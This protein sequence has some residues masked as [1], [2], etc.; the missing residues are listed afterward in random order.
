[1]KSPSIIRIIFVYPARSNDQRNSGFG[2]SG[3][4]SGG[5]DLVGLFN[6]VIICLHHK[7]F[8]D[9]VDEISPEMTD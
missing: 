8:T 6:E 7:F 9:D 5:A 2:D 4:G 3:G 1:M